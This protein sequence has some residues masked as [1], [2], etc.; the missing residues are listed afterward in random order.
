MTDEE[1]EKQKVKKLQGRATKKEALKYHY[2]LV[3]ALNQKGFQL[4][5]DRLQFQNN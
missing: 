3:S 5:F 1:K 4:I 2:W